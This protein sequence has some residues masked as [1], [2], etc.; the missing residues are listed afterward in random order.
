MLELSCETQVDLARSGL[1]HGAGLFETL[2]L[3]AGVPRWI[4]LHL[5]RL[6]AGCAFLGFQAPPELEVVASFVE[7]VGS[8]IAY[9][10]LRL[11]AADGV[12][13]VF[14]EPLPPREPVPASLGRSLETV[15]FSGDPLLRFKTLSYL[16]NLRM[17][18]EAAERGLF[19]VVALN[20]RG[21]LTDGG[22][23]SLFAVIGGQVYTPPVSEG[24]LP[25]VA[26]RIL[27]EAGLATEGALRWED[28]E[29]AEALFLANALRGVIP[30]DRVEGRSGWEVA[31][32]AILRAVAA[33]EE[34]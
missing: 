33:L 23:T 21:R 10:V 17:A 15:R 34:K 2:R 16:P 12:L 30:V 31:H 22:R 25:G 11:V 26:R 9:G 20:E 24:A 6:A 1:R 32:P 18:A 29:R 14:A 13:R 3:E 8:G 19:E 7:S 4:D 28:L 5:E 27:L